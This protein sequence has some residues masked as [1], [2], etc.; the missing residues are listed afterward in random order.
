MDKAKI[1]M[2]GK[3]QAIRLPKKYRI[4]GKEVLIQEHE[5]GFLVIDPE[6]RWKLLEKVMGKMGDDFF[7]NDRD[8]GEWTEREKFE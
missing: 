6:K 4:N 2:N 1:F 3:S 8:Q 5:L 7:P